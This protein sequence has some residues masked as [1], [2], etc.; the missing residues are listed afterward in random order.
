MPLIRNDE[1]I[2][3]L[4]FS[5]VDIFLG[6]RDKLVISQTINLVKKNR[7]LAKKIIIVKIFCTHILDFRDRRGGLRYPTEKIYF[8][9]CS[10]M[11]FFVTLC[12]LGSSIFCKVL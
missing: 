8:Q 10:L 5:C 1:I 11:K 12:H 3:V 6:S 9:E 7:L 2:K 4:Q